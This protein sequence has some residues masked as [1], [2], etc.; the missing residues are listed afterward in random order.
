MEKE[1]RERGRGRDGGR[2]ERGEKEWGEGGRI[3]EGIV[4][5]M[6][7]DREEEHR[8]RRRRRRGRW[9]GQEGRGVGGREGN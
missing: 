8:R 6:V 9:P 7:K 5:K 1:V 2:E 4:R 3:K